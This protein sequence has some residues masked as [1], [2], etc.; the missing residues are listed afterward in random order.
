M[1]REDRLRRRPRERRLPGKHLVSHH[2]NGVQVGARIYRGHPRGLLRGHVVRGA[3]REAERRERAA[4]GAAAGRGGAGGFGHAEVHHQSVPPAEHD[5]LG[6][7][8][9]VHDPEAVRVSQ[10]IQHLLEDPGRVAGRQPAL[11]GQALPQALPLHVGHDVVEHAWAHVILARDLARIDERQDVRVL[12]VRGDAD[13]TQEPVGAECAGHFGMEHFDGDGPIVLEVVRQ[14]HRRHP[15]TSHFP[16]DDVDAGESILEHLA[17][18]GHGCPVQKG[19]ASLPNTTRKAR[20]QRD[21]SHATYCM[22]P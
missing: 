11:A 18:I 8:V 14:K 1:R 2:P 17:E 10:R 6:L 7:D 3:D 4:G 9:A 21:S 5:V 13:L 15:A 19:K 16:L 12:E 22:R 20:R